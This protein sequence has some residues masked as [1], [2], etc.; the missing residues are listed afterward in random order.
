LG[1]KI[2]WFFF[3]CECVVWK[4]FKIKKFTGK[5]FSPPPPKL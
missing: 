5:G 3:G 1:K 2:N 4:D